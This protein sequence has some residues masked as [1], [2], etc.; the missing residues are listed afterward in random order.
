MSRFF[1]KFFSSFSLN[2]D[3]FMFMWIIA[4]V[5][6]FGIAVAIERIY[7]IMVRS[8]VNAI[9]FMTEIRKDVAG[10]NLDR[11]IKLCESGKEKALP[12][13]VLTALKRANASSELDFRA[14]Q[15]AVDEATLEVIP[16]LQERT[17]YLSMIANV[18]TLIGL[19]GTI[20]GLILSFD[21]V[22]SDAIAEADKTKYL[23]QGISAAMNTTIFGLAVAI[24]TLIVYTLINSKTQ[25]I[26]DEMDE[27]LVKLINLITGNR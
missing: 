16:K 11:A 3:A 26:I 20:F 15:N 7:F 5:G 17:P 23:A 12:Y 10:N 6:A 25:K 2:D 18:A 13:V 14:I 21:A 24:P 27:H 19:M 1:S 8:N 4:I 9:K 22:S